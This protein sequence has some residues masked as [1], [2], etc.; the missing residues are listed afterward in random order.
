M[1]R[2]KVATLV[3]ITGTVAS[4]GL[5]ACSIMLAGGPPIGVVSPPRLRVVA[6]SKF[7]KIVATYRVTN[8]GGRDLV[9]GE[10]ETS[11]GCTVA[12]ISPKVV[13]PGGYAE[14]TVEGSSTDAGEKDVFVRIRS[15]GRPQSE[16]LFQLTMVGPGQPPYVAYG[17]E[18]VAFGIV[19]DDLTTQE[20]QVITREKAGDVPW[21]SGVRSTLTGLA[22]TGGMASEHALGDVVSRHYQFNTLNG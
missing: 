22:I 14:V 5:L 21:I 16:L 1:T 11:C 15:N 8:K 9:L 2:T 12:S 20:F 6:E 7:K 17:T 19:H 10:A 13:R 18:A 3:G 4:I